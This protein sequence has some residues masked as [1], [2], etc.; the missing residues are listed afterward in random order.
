MGRSGRA[1]WYGPGRSYHR[2]DDNDPI[3]ISR[4]SRPAQSS[5]NRF[6]R[7]Y[8]G[9]RTRPV[10]LL[11]QG[12]GCTRRGPVEIAIQQSDVLSMVPDDAAGTPRLSAGASAMGGPSDAQHVGPCDQ[13]AAQAPAS[14]AARD[15]D[16][17]HD[18]LSE[19]RHGVA[20]SG[21]SGV[22]PGVVPRAQQSARRHLPRVCRPHDAGRRHPDAYAGGGGRGAGSRGQGARI[23]GDTDARVRGPAGAGGRAKDSPRPPV[24]HIGS[25]PSLWTA[26]TTTI[27]FGPNAWS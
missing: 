6:R 8:R 9:V 25:T 11:A 19:L 12:R 14:A 7:P 13:F 17:L 4:Y 20:E 16:R 21:R 22:A 24:T 26:S 5:D 10:R 27:R 1:I 18:H 15:G 23:Q 2:G 3:Q